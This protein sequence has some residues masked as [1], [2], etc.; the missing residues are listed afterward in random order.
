MSFKHLDTLI[1]R[2]S[3]R[4][5]YSQTVHPIWFVERLIHK[6]FMKSE[7]LLFI[8][9]AFGIVLLHDKDIYT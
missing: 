9:F 4:K 7:E 5:T 8:W 1:K 2:D 6:P 3:Y